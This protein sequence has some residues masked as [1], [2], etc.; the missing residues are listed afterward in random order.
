MSMDPDTLEHVVRYI[1]DLGVQLE[2]LM[3]RRQYGGGDLETG[4]WRNGSAGLVRM[5]TKQNEESDGDDTEFK[6]KRKCVSFNKPAHEALA[7]SDIST[8][9]A[10][11]QDVEAESS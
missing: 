10:A 3:N 9:M 8:G 7:P 2:E 6:P 1:R 5:T 4:V 11:L